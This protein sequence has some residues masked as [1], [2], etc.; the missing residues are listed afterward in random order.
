M[1][2]SSRSVIRKGQVKFFNDEKGY[3]FIID[4]E[5]KDS[6]FVHMNN[7]AESIRENDKVTFEI[8]MGPKGANAVNVKLVE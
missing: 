8:E 4:E 3:G 6:L 1:D 7:T 5:T 2:K